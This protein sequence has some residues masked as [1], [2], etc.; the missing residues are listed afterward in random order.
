[1]GFCLLSLI[2]GWIV[3][4]SQHDL[5]NVSAPEL[6][7]VFVASDL[8]TNM[9]VSLERKKKLINDLMLQNN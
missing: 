4:S 1:M 8:L 7:V 9:R 5:S 2:F 6:M 3:C